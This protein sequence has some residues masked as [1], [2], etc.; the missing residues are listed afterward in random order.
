MDIIDLHCDTL[1]RAV[2]EDKSLDS[3]EMEVRLNDDPGFRKLQCY[4]IWI[5][6]DC[7]GEEA[8]QLWTEARNR[9]AKECR[10]HRIALIKP[11]E[12]ASDAFFQNRNSAFF[13]VENGKA[14]N[15]KISNVAK[16]AS[17]GVRMMTLTWNARNEIGDGVMADEPSGI[18]DFG[19]QVVREME[20]HHIIVDISHA[21]PALFYDVAAIAKRPFVA[22]HSNSFS[23]TG[24]PR[25]LTNEQFGVIRDRGG[26]VGV[27]FHNAFLNDAPEKASLNDIIRH[28]DH[29]LS[30]GGEDIICFGSD[31]DGG[32]LPQD[33]QDSRVYDTLYEVFLQN[34]YKERTIRKIFYEN[35]LNFFE[36]FDNP[37]N[38]V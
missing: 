36:N 29:F 37:Q 31:F 13:T 1:Y 28:T 9:I 2:T 27:N 20:R 3:D 7:T 10:V 35:A 32:V 14:L 33:F 4:A 22:S 8:E 23:V 25:N 30:I 21:S 18:T 34:R 38:M 12:R 15:G 26:L 6:D 11:G 16:Y 17:E 24:H 19:K 5:P